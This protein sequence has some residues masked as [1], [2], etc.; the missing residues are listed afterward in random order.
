M[1]K[2]RIIGGGI[3]GLSLGIY[4]RK[5]GVEV[6]LIESGTYP[7]HKV[8]GEFICGVSPTSMEEMGLRD[9]LAQSV[10]HTQMRW[11]IKDSVVFEDA[12]PTVAWGLS[13]YKLDDDLAA[14]FTSRGGRLK[15]GKRVAQE[16]EEGVVWAT[17][18]RKKKGRWIG[19]KVHALD[20]LVDAPIDGLEMHVGSLGYIGLCGIEDEKVN[21]CG[22]FR[23]DQSIKGTGSALMEAYLR[24]NGLTALADRF[25]GWQ[26]DETSFCATAGFSFGKQ[27][28]VGDFCVGDSSYLI[29]PFT[30][31]GMS[32]ALESSWMAGPWLAR[33][34]QG[35]IRWEEACA[36]YENEC[37]VFFKKRMKLSRSMQP[38]LLSRLGRTLLKSAARSGMLPFE[39]LFHQLRTP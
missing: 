35:E 37:V 5:L 9:V 6:E 31:N 33:F 34:S 7:K 27:P 4:L 25:S 19:L 26:K 29:P 39:F 24:A 10:E 32:M 18:K 3:A 14:L 20:A 2:I 11:W 17:G 36:G 13:R 8:C 16:D 22:L 28:Q 15:T 23:V 38:L 12:L 30:G 1:K 21:C